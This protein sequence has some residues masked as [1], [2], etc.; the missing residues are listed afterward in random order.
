MSGPQ[1]PTGD[2]EPTRVRPPIQPGSDGGWGSSSPSSPSNPSNPPPA[3]NPYGGQSYPGQS[4]QTQLPPQGGQYGQGQ[5]DQGQY[6]QYPAQGG[7]YPAPPGYAQ[8]PGA[9]QPQQPQQGRGRSRKLLIGGISA[10][11][12]LVLVVVGGILVMQYLEKREEERAAEEKANQ[13]DAA[14]AATDDFFAA[15]ADGSAEDALALLSSEPEDTTLL[16]DDIVAAAQEDAPVAV[17]DTTLESIS[18]NLEE[19]QVTTL[20]TVGGE[21]AEWVLDLARDG[22][23]WQITTE[24]PTLTVDGSDTIQVNGT[25]VSAGEALPAFPGTYA[26]ATGNDLVEFT[27]GSAVVVEQ[28]ETDWSGEDATQLTEAGEGWVI[29]RGYASLQACV[30]VKELSPA[31]CPMSVSARPEQEVD[32]RTITRRI[33]NDPW[34]DATVA[35][36]GDTATVSVTLTWEFNASGLANGQRATFTQGGT[37]TATFIIDGVSTDAPTESWLAI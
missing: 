10:L 13:E 31:N 26:F 18:G 12:V 14:V 27:S 4:D 8:Y 21:S 6:G 19:A 37:D 7:G 9:D 20:V 28:T 30:A 2:D 24:L 5:H 1:N 32:T 25:E 16:T 3:S 23:D 17:E 11:L 35:F 33:T 34:A 36:S 15:L 29:D 22:D